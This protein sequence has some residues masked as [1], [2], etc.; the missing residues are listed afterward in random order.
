LEEFE[1]SPAYDLLSTA[2][3]IADDKEETALTINGK[4]SRLK[5]KDFDALALSMNINTKALESIYT[6]F[7]KVLPNWI[8]FIKQS[9]LSKTM[10]KKYIELIQGK[11][12]NLFQ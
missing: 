4:K 2:L 8:D 9:F 3:V 10:Q 11:H 12:K 1:L 7:E 6:K 5:K